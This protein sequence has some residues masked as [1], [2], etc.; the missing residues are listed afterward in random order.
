MVG[1]ASIEADTVLDTN[2]PPQVN[3]GP[4]KEG[5]GAGAEQE[6]EARRC[7]VAF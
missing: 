5:R 4:G 6:R 7:V 1:S 3:N 2:T